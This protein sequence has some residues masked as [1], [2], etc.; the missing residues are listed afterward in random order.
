MATTVGGEARRVAI[1]LRISKDDGSQ[2]NDKQLLQLR[3]FCGR[4]EGTDGNPPSPGHGAAGGDGRSQAHGR[5]SAT[6]EAR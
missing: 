3:E 5:F 1:C 4:R 6:E 2:Q